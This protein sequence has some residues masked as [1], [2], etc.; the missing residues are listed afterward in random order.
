M[1]GKQSFQKRVMII[2]KNGNLLNI[3]GLNKGKKLKQ[4]TPWHA[5]FL[6]DG[7]SINGVEIIYNVHLH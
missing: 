3:N 7:F 4:V 2:K 6:K 1:D 5:K